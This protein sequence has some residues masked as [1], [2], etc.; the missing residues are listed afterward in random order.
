MNSDGA[1]VGVVKLA[2]HSIGYVEGPRH[3]F[4]STGAVTTGIRTLRTWSSHIYSLVFNTGL[5]C[6]YKTLFISLLNL[7]NNESRKKPELNNLGPV[8][9]RNA[10]HSIN[11]YPVDG[12]VCFYNTYPV[13]LSGGYRHPLFKQLAPAY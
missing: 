13:D 7:R 6:K 12:V 2:Q 3:W 11:N 4:Q 1:W 10:V 8:I 5:Q 9:Q